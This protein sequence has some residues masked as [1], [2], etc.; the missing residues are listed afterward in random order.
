MEKGSPIYP[1][2]PF[3]KFR[4][5]RIKDGKL[6]VELILFG[7]RQKEFPELILNFPSHL[8]PEHPSAYGLPGGAKSMVAVKIPADSLPMAG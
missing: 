3:S 2:P 1:T 8:L 6:I 7:T 4:G 5:G